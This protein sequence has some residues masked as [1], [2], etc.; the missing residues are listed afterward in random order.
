MFGNYVVRLRSVIDGRGGISGILH[1]EITELWKPLRHWPLRVYLIDNAA[2][3]EYGL[4]T[5]V[6]ACK[7]VDFGECKGPRACMTRFSAKL[8]MEDLTII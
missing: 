7:R 6:N 1:T 8:I 4:E 2:V 3:V 5:I